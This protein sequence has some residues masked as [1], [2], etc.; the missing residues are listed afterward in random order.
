MDWTEKDSKNT[1]RNCLQLKTS[2]T[3]TKETVHAAF[4]MIKYRTDLKDKSI[5]EKIFYQI[6]TSDGKN[7][8]AHEFKDIA[9]VVDNKF[10]ILVE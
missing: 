5:S 2:P 6:Q 1:G 3:K 10:Y 4:H 7:D 9:K 8:I